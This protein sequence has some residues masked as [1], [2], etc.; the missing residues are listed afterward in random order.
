MGA[1]R[2][3]PYGEHDRHKLD[4]FLPADV[5]NGRCLFL[6][7]G[8]GWSGGSRDQ[9]HPVAERFSGHGYVA[10]SA[11][12]RLAPEAPWPAQIEDVRAALALTRELASEY[13]FDPSRVAA[14]GS[15]AGGHLVAMLATIGAGDEPGLGSLP[16]E[17][18]TRPNAVVCYCPVT[19]IAD[20][21]LQSG[22]LSAAYG[23]LMGDKADRTPR[24]Y[25][26][27]GAVRSDEWRLEVSGCACRSGSSA[28]SG[29][30][31]RIRRQYRT[32]A[33][34][35]GR[36][37]FVPRRHPR[38]R[39]LPFYLLPRRG[40]S[41]DSPSGGLATGSE[42]EVGVPPTQTAAG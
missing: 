40:R 25:V 19:T 36:N 7:H 41:P 9:W 31:L 42:I 21:D 4:V 39:C 13:G 8:G 17:T 5:A 20:P 29:P 27:A 2:T 6:V 15:S 34:V 22:R 11:G 18:D 14:M 38:I 26:A 37:R 33:A 23:K 32:S 10:V 30:R 35:A 16:L 1:M 24:A 3:V 28:G 12:Y